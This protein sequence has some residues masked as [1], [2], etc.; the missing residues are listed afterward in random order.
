MRGWHHGYHFLG[1][2]DALLQTDRIDIGEVRT[3]LL[4]A[5]G[6]R[7]QVNE[8]QTALL[9][10]AVNR[11][12]HDIPGCQRLQGRILVHKR[13]TLRVLQNRPFASDGF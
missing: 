8:R 6:T 13:L 5:D 10:F 11:T 9:D 4:L 7:I 2:I 1:H 12:R 3:Y